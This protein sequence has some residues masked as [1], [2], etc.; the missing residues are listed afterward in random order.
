V[1]KKKKIGGVIEPKE[2]DLAERGC[3]SLIRDHHEIIDAAV[4]E[5]YGWPLEL[6]DQEKLQNLI[7]LNKDRI[8]EE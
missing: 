6:S 8:K 2:R 1:G 5:A 7:L 4:A 3:V